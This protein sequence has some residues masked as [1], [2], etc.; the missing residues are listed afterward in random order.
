MQ[1][2]LEYLSFDIQSIPISEKIQSSPANILEKRM[3]EKIDL[4]QQLELKQK[5]ILKMMNKCEKELEILNPKERAIIRLY[6]FT[7]KTWEEVAGEFGYTER[8]VKKISKSG[9]CKLEEKGH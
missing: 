4:Q 8:H 5:N 9:L 6:F 2:T 1:S 7:N 3:I